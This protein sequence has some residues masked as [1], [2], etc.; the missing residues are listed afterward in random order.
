[1]RERPLVIPKNASE[2]L[3]IGLD[4]YRG[5]E[6]LSLRIWFQPREGGDRRPGKDGFALRVAKLPELIDALHEIEA[7]ARERG[8]LPDGGA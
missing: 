5:V 1:M 2:E 4:E 7:E 6:I 8:L 3:R